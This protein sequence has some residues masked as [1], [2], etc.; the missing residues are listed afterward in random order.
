MAFTVA[1]FTGE[2]WRNVHVVAGY[3]LL[4]LLGFRLLWGFVGPQHVRFS[5][6]V[7]PPHGKNLVKAMINGRKHG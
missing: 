1:Y 5:D 3:T 7:Y 4:G 6:F 2:D